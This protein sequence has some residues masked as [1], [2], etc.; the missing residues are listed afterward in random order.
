MAPG[1][2]RWEREDGS[3]VDEVGETKGLYG[4]R[5]GREERAPQW[6]RWEGREGS[7]VKFLNWAM[8]EGLEEVQHDEGG[9]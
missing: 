8:R 9:S 2:T 7:T 4:G 1:W 6:T 5:G 3:T